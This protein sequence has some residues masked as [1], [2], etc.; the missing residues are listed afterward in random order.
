MNDF[1]WNRDGFYFVGTTVGC[2]FKHFFVV[3][4][5][6]PLSGHLMYLGGNVFNISMHLHT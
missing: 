3:I 6:K 2:N 4:F 1:C 5:L